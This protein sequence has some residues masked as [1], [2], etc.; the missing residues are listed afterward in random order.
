MSK[1]NKITINNTSYNIKDRV[2]R[3]YSTIWETTDPEPPIPPG[4]PVVAMYVDDW[5]YDSVE[6]TYVWDDDGMSKSNWFN[7]YFSDLDRHGSN[8]YEY[9]EE[10]IYNNT[11][12]Y[13]FEN[14][15]D[16]G[17]NLNI[18]KYLLI[19]TR[20]YNI[21]YRQSVEYSLNNTDIHPIIAYLDDDFEITYD[22]NHHRPLEDDSIVAVYREQD[23]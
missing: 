16:N 6:G 17:E 12:Y 22:E 15:Y 13:L 4:E 11:T 5:K 19:D 7:E 3:E 8:Y 9:V 20:D 2:A 1:I 18:V 10:F 14:D 23:L 21:L